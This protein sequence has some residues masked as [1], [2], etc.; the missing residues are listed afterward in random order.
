PAAVAEVVAELDDLRDATE[1]LGEADGAS[2][3]LPCKIVDGDLA[4]VEHRVGN[5]FQMLVDE[6][7]DHG[8]V[9]AYRR[10]AH[11][12]VV[13]HHHH[14]AP[15]PAGRWSSAPALPT[16]G[17][18]SARPSLSSALVRAGRSPSA[19]PAARPSPCAPAR[20][21][22]A[23]TTRPHERLREQTTCRA[24]HGVPGPP[25]PRPAPPPAGR[26]EAR[27]ASPPSSA[28]RRALR[29]AGAPR[30]SPS[31]PVALRRATA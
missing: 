22:A 8:D 29:A 15:A 14:P 27:A 10:R 24:A 25:A 13:S 2:E 18:R 1:V 19:A 12:L 9:L 23:A 7:L 28:G 31:R 30:D 11:L 6:L 4:V 17:A 21:A 26:R 20:R 5:V 3:R 16:R